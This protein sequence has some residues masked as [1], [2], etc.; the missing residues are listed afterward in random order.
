M[1]SQQTLSQNHKAIKLNQGKQTQS[2][3]GPRIFVPHIFVGGST[4]MSGF[5]G[6]GRRYVGIV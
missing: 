5:S 1:I 4:D 3:K 6:L 2:E